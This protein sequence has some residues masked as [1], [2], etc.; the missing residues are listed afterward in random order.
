ML[1]SNDVYVKSTVNMT[2]I[3]PMQCNKLYI[4]EALDWK[5]IERTPWA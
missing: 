2:L 5:P 3:E 4:T 1:L